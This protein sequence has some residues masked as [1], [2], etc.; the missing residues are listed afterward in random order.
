VIDYTQN[1]RFL[2]VKKKSFSLTLA[3]DTLELIGVGAEMNICVGSYGERAV[4]K[5]CIIMI[6][7]EDSVSVGCIELRDGSVV[8]AKGVRNTL[9][10]NCERDFIKSWAAIKGLNIATNDL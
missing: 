5:S 2:E 10:Q 6:L 9:L 7:R 3:K 4:S 8:Q 1:E